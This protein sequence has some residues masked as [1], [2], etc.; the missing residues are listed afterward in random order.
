[1]RLS[2]FKLALLPLF[3]LLN[4]SKYQQLSF[5]KKKTKNKIAAFKSHSTS[6]I[7]SNN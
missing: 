2:G 4:Q 3:S 6:F 5:F 7:K 1:M